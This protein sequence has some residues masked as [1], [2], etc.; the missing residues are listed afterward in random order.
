MGILYP[1]AKMMWEA[2]LARGPFHEVV[3]VGHQALFL[4][5]REVRLL[6]ESY[7]RQFPEA[8]AT[9]PSGYTF[10]SYSDAFLEQFIGVESLSILDC[11]PYEGANIIHDLNDPVP[12]H[13]AGRFDA[14]IDGGSLEHVFNF[15]VAI[16][17]MMR[18]LKVGGTLFIMNPANNLCG[19]GFYQFSPELM[20][21]IFTRANGFELKRVALEEVDFAGIELKPV[22]GVYEVV[23]PAIAGKR[24]CL[25]SKR[26]AMVMVEACKTSEVPLFEP[27]PQ[28]S[29]YVA[30][31]RQEWGESARKT[32][33]RRLLGDLFRRMPTRL[34]NTVFGH[35]AKREFSLSNRQV[36][37]ALS[38][39]K[40]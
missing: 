16:A 34:Q 33:L 35:L 30:L 32:P 5:P 28:Q 22:R 40:L 7:R 1:D 11:S 15:P 31:W 27:P 4:Y 37:R 21:R 24:V 19:H 9:P 39:G 20:F 8:S 2:R 10:G 25:Q 23:D 14:V 6:R 17:S 29:D 36:Y 38:S 13:L 18:M 3:T 12:Q 26:A